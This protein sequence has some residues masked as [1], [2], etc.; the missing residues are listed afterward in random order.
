MTQEQ[1]K[2]RSRRSRRRRG[3]GRKAWQGQPQQH[4][5]HQAQNQQVRGDDVPF[6]PQPRIEV[7]GI[8]ELGPD[9][10]GWLRCIDTNYVPTDDDPHIPA[11]LARAENLRPGQEIRA[12]AERVKGRATVVDLVTVNGNAAL[13]TASTN[14][15]ITV[16]TFV[17]TGAIGVHTTGDSANHC[18]AKKS[19]SAALPASPPAT[20]PNS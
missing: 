17:A 16:D 10:Q 8:L 1:T 12:T 13:T 4:G 3:K 2:T 18:P 15:V 19:A 6:G 9:G 11:A 5:H 7:S 20:W 14:S